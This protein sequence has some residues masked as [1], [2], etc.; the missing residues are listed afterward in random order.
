LLSAAGFAA[1]ADTLTR[2]LRERWKP[3]LISWAETGVLLIVSI[4]L[5]FYGLREYFIVMPERNPPQFEDIVSW[6]S[7]RT[8]EPLTIVYLDSTEKTPHRV[9]YLINTKMVPHKYLSV[10][11]FDFNW[12]ELPDRSIVFIEPGEEGYPAP[13]ST[14]KNSVTYLNKERE[15]IGYG[16]SNTDTDLQPSSPFPITHEEFPVTIIAILSAL[17]I[18]ALLLRFVQI[19]ISTERT[20]TKPSLRIHIEITLRKTVKGEADEGT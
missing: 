11:P 9:E 17:A 20:T 12:Q 7:W 6:I 16:W 1:S 18:F 15:T 19:R 5:V 3:A 13:A 4:V 14:F 10:A 8:E 2:D